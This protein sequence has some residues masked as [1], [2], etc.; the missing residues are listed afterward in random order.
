MSPAE[1]NYNIHNKKL[2]TIVECLNQWRIYTE[3]ASEFNIYTDYKNLVS[4]TTIKILNWKQV[5]WLK[6]LKQYKFKIS[7]TP[8]KDNSR[9][10][11]LSQQSNYMKT[12]EVFNK[13]ILKINN[14]GTLSANSKHK[15]NTTLQILR[16]EEKWFSIKKE[17]YLI[18]NNRINKCIWNYHDDSAQKHSEVIKTL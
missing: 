16:N 2:L 12:K 8:G 18:M 10:N 5:R 17:K 11:A 6:L 7:Y 3:E 13:S 15:L 9:A 14:N 1:Q 4:F